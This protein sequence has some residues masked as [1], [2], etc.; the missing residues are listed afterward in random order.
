MGHPFDTIKTKM[1]AQ[2]EHIGSKTSK[3]GYIE[4]VKNVAY[5]EGPLGF[6]R[7]CVPPFFGS[8]IYRSVQ[9]AVFEAFYTKWEKSAEM[10]KAIPF[11]GGLEWRVLFAGILGGSARSF[12][13][14]PFE[15]AKVKGQTG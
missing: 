2:T 1:Q 3:I 14:C 7:G 12:I 13:E 8:V 4:T 5:K 9:F 15:Y 10:T 11:T 6:Y